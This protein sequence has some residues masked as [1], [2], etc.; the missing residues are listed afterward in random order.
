MGQLLGTSQILIHPFVVAELALGSLPKRFE[1]LG[2]LDSLPEA[3]L[4]R[5][6]EVRLLIESRPLFSRR[7]GLTDAHLLASSLL[8]PAC[9]LWTRDKALRSLA[10]TLML[11]ADLP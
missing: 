11:D 7:I 4:A 3:K 8:T 2:L 5:L 10:R 1:T 9:R 6:D